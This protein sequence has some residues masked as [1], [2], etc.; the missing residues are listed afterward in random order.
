MLVGAVKGLEVKSKEAW[1]QST[2]D[3]HF[4]VPAKK[5]GIHKGGLEVPSNSPGK[6]L[7][8]RRIR[9]GREVKTWERE[10]ERDESGYVYRTP[11]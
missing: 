1:G 8:I 4:E 6:A 5:F 9:E 11:C 3:E 2:S 7:M 10:K